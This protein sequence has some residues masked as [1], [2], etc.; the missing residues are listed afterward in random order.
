MKITYPRPNNEAARALAVMELDVD[1][2]DLADMFKDL[3][4]LAARIA[5]T[6]ISLVNLIDTYTQWT[7]ANH[8]LEIEQ[9]P[10]EDSVCTYTI[11]APESFEI[12]MLSE[13]ER[14]QDKFYVSGEPYLNYYFGIP[15]KT[16]NGLNLGALCVMDKQ[17]KQISPEKVELL[18]IVANEIANRLVSLKSLQDLRNQVKAAQQAKEKVAHDIRGPLG[19]IINLAQLLASEGKSYKIDEVIEF[20]QMI[21]KAGNSLLDLSTEILSNEDKSAQQK[22]DILTLQQFSDKLNRLYQPQALNKEIKLSINIAPH[23]AS[24]QFPKNKLLQIAGN[25]ITNAIKFTG[26]QGLVMVDLDAQQS[27]DALQLFINISDTGVGMDTVAIDEILSGEK[28][29]DMGTAGEAG[30]GFG[31]PL[32]KRLVES[33]NGSMAIQSEQ[34]KGTKFIVNIN[35][36]NPKES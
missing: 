28:E 17:P 22:S 14:F 1:Y 21:Y 9:M 11:A 34:G 31:L 26:N 32:V 35:Y 4:R 25:L 36:N 27:K 13:D 6:E 23:A 12:K 16:S 5:G 33:L 7:I 10:R 8:G 29:S 2:T 30:Y 18:K 3:T 24:V 20:M 19:G 15:L